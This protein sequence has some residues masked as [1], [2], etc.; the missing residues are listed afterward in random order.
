MGPIAPAS[1]TQLV[2]RGDRRWPIRFT[3]RRPPWLPSEIMAAIRL[4]LGTA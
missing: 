1:V 4:R 3:R 2:H